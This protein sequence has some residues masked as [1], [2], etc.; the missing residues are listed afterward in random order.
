M[1]GGIGFVALFYIRRLVASVLP[2]W[3]KAVDL[4]KSLQGQD[5]LIPGWYAAGRAAFSGANRG[6]VT[7]L[8]PPKT[9]HVSLPTDSFLGLIMQDD[10]S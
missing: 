2:A 8:E 3:K 5:L 10:S 6:R 9:Y 7:F 4:P 1:R